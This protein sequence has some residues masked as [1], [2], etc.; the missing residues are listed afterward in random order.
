MRQN[1]GSSSPLFPRTG[2]VRYEGE[3]AEWHEHDLANWNLYFTF[4]GAGEIFFLNN[5]MRTELGELLLLPPTLRRSYRVEDPKAGWGFYFL[6]FRPTKSLLKNVSWFRQKRPQVY[7]LANPTARNR[8]IAT[9]DEM[10]QIN[11][12]TP[13]MKERPALMDALLETLILRVAGGLKNSKLSGSGIDMRVEKAVE[14]FHEDF[15]KQHSISSL[16]EAAG[17]SRS[18]FCLLFRAG[19]GRSPQEYMEERRLELARIYLMTT[20]SLVSE[21][22]INVG[23]DDPFYFCTRFKRRFG[24]SPSAY[25]RANLRAGTDKGVWAPS[26]ILSRNGHGI[27]DH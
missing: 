11:L 10:F 5:Q 14:V 25:R 27:E 9:L 20:A 21:T 6:H 26:M 7:P 19:M 2:Y 23:F 12:R 1:I 3:S 8:T 22:A 18:Q 15:R 17:L 24:L 13:E 16:A 4:L